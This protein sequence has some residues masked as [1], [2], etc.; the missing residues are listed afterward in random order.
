LDLL[1][2][3][4][5]SLKKRFES[6][7]LQRRPDGSALVIVPDLPLPQGWLKKT[8]GVLFVVPNGYPQAR[9]DSFWA[10]PDLRL[11]HGGMPANTG[12]N[13]NYGGADP[14]LWFSYHPSGWNPNLDDLSTYLN[15]IK[16]RLRE[17]R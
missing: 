8:C 17:A 1:D 10:D 3:H 14:K 12:I 13:A 6:A 16:S 7:L 2:Q 11:A 9:P 5:E 15:L 4:F